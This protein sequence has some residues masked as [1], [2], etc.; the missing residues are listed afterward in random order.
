MSERLNFSD[1]A[2][3][4]E[5]VKKLG[6]IVMGVAAEYGK[7][8]ASHRGEKAHG[9]VDEIELLR[10]EQET[11]AKLIRHRLA[12]RMAR[13]LVEVPAED[14]RKSYSVGAR[15]WSM[16]LIDT[17]WFEHDDNVWVGSRNTMQF[18]WNND[19]VTQAGRSMLFV[20]SND[21]VTLARLA[22]NEDAVSG[23]LSAEEWNDVFVTQDDYEQVTLHDM[24]QVIDDIGSYMRLNRAIRQ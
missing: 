14:P 9:F 18:R 23:G 13:Q 20:P 11:D 8:R 10:A 24:E 22:N 3:T 16:Q 2:P 7:M 12:V 21:E 15:E 19:K 5:Q 6:N 4:P 1:T 17:Q